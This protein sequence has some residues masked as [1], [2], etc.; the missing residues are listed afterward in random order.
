MELQELTSKLPT[1]TISQIAR[2]IAKDWGNKVYFGAKP[3]LQ[4]MFYVDNLSDRYGL[5]DGKTQVIYFLSNASTWRG[6]TAKAVKKELNKRL[7]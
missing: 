4:A 5:E 3:Y 2:I 6:E 7:K 1:M